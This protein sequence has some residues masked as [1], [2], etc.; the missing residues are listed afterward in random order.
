MNSHTPTPEPGQE[1]VVPGGGSGQDAQTA[2]G[3]TGSTPAAGPG[4]SRPAPPQYGLRAADLGLPSPYEQY[5][6][7]QE[8]EARAR[9]AQQGGWQGQAQQPG[10]YAPQPGPYAPQPGAQSWQSPVNPAQ[11]F[12]GTPPEKPEE[13]R[14]IGWAFWLLLSACAFGLIASLQTL[15]SVDFDTLF[16]AAL[17]EA[18][19]SS[20]YTF[21]QESRESLKT[22][23]FV[24]M[25][26]GFLINVTLYILVAVF[27]RKG[28]Q[29][30]RILGTILAA[31]SVTGFGAAMILDLLSIVCGIVAMV[32]CWLPDSNVFFARTKLHRDF[33]KFARFRAPN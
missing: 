17:T 4:E 2:P 5:Q 32:L 21:S 7:E 6:R 8:A 22:L 3:Q 10:P 1:P 20:S 14:T 29:W 13:P 18:S 30:A 12:Q 9:A 25:I 23:F 28:R 11:W 19:K 27:V 24:T 31:I 16:N 33:Q 26:L 15:L